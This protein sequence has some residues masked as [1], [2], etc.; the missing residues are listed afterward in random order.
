MAIYPEFPKPMYRH[1]QEQ[2]AYAHNDKQVADYIKEGYTTTYIYRRY[3]LFMYGPQ[4]EVVI[5]GNQLE[6]DQHIEH[7][8]TNQAS[9]RHVKREE[10]IAKDALVEEVTTLKHEMASMTQEREEIAALKQELQD[11][12]AQ[13]RSERKK[14]A[15]APKATE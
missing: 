11:E 2:P 15:K 14:A 8:Y 5:V 6:E 12:L 4:D 3:P 9:D 7:G 10:P 1:D 13:L